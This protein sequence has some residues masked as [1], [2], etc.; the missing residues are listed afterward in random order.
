[1][2][3]FETDVFKV[4]IHDNLIKEFTVKKGIVL[5][6][7]HLWESVQLSEKY[8]PGS[9]YF[10][11]FEGEENSDITADAKRAGASAEYAK[12]VAALALYS[13]KMLETIRGN[14]FLK[15]NR[16]IVP[17]RFFDNR[18]KAMDWLR[19]KTSFVRS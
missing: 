8:K 6:E 19:Q 1:M 13:D 10:V 12:Y 3:Q 16:P 2:K 7:K 4:I 15:I 17:T 9:R 18:E 14:L 5:E 11:L